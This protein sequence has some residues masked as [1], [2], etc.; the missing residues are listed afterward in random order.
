M[1]V[2]KEA[3][4]CVYSAIRCYRPKTPKRNEKGLEGGRV[5]FR[6]AELRILDLLDF[7]GERE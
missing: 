2:L 3:F 6:G 5:A 1:K 7:K 4:L